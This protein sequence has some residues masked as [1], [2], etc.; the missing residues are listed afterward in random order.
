MT[1]HIDVL[2]TIQE[3]NN[4]RAQLVRVYQDV[5]SRPPWNEPPEAVSA[6]AERALL[7]AQRPAFRC[8]TAYHTDGGDLVGFAYGYTSASGQWWHDTIT[9][10][11][12]AEEVEQWFSNAF[13]LV[14]LAVLP[15]AQG[16]GIGGQLHDRIFAG[17]PHRTAV[18]NTPRS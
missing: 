8:V 2:T 16:Q 3:L 11:L 5:F 1:V 4:V 13:E 14:E 7:H 12:S 17:I 6:F 9:A 18:R 15:T 10:V